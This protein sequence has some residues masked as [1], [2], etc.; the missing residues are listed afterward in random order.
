M[1][2]ALDL[3]G[4]G[5]Y[6]VSP[7]PMVGAVLVRDGR[8]VGEG[9]HRR[10]GGPHAEVE[11]IRAAG[12]GARGAD[13]YVTLEP[14]AHV[15]KTPPCTDAILEAGIRRVFFAAR[16]PNPATCGRGPVALRR[17][18]LEVRAG[19]LEEAALEQN[20]PYFHWRRT[21]RPWVILK[22]AMSADGRMALPSG[23]SRW[24]SGERSRAEAH[25]LRRRVDAVVA[26]TETLRRDDPQL[27]PRPARG[28]EPLRVVLDRRA[29]LP[30]SLQILAPGGPRRLYATSKRCPE[31]RRRELSRRGLEVLIVPEEGGELDLRALLSALGQRGVSQLLVEGG[32]ALHGGFLDAGLAQELFVFVAP[33]IIGA[34]E[35]PGPVAGEGVE[36]LRDSVLLA[37]CRVRRCGDD[38]LLTGRWPRPPEA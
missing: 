33:R 22:W 8:I 26:G 21:G 24:I 30:W 3:A 6:S 27:L 11:A 31:S 12:R 9:W 10:F 13:L 29:R 23:E 7:N 38:V 17:R 36:R 2:R 5:R 16:D 32:A 15:G 20:A 35:A 18:G 14:C 37:S 4:R 1:R 25:R 19:L 28:R 34:R